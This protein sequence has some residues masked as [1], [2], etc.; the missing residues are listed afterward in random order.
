M[1]LKL[2]LEIYVDGFANKC[3]KKDKWKYYYKGIVK[4]A[5]TTY[6]Y[7]MPHFQKVY[8]ILDKRKVTYF[9]L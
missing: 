2:E 5:S 7:H 1:S 4:L 9:V 8:I 6:C 3:I